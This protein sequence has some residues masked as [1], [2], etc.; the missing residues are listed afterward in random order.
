MKLSSVGRNYAQIFNRCADGIDRSFSFNDFCALSSPL[1]L[2]LLLPMSGS[3]KV[4]ERI[5]GAAALAVERVNADNTLLP[6][7]RLEYSWTD[8]GCSAQQGLMAIGELLSRMSK[9]DG[10]IDAVIGGC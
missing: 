3:W 7:H 8:S 9:V 2:A 4:G 10:K 6:G 5:A 1:H